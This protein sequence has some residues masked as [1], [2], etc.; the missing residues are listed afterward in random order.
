[1]RNVSLTYN[2]NRRIGIDRREFSYT[3]YLPE[4]RS[5]QDRRGVFDYRCILT[6]E[7]G[8]DIRTCEELEGRPLNYKFL[9]KRDSSQI[10][11]L[12]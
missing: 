4:R 2:K 3:A 6:K 7:I 10:S 9:L 1:M 5:G 12:D 8:N 11:I